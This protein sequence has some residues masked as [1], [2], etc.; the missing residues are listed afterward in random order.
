M[1]T[2]R[3]LDPTDIPIKSSL[4]NRP[5]SQQESEGMEPLLS[6]LH[7]VHFLAWSSLVCPNPEDLWKMGVFF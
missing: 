5:E 6:A 4:K 2:I 1:I 3:F 7:A